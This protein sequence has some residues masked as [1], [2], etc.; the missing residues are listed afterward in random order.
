MVFAE[1]LGLADALGSLHRGTPIRLCGVWGPARGLVLSAIGKASG[2]PL[3]VVTRN[4][5]E[6]ELVAGD[7]GQYLAPGQAAVFPPFAGRCAGG[8]ATSL[9]V[10]SERITALSRLLHRDLPVVVIPVQ[11]L[12]DPLIPADALISATMHLY[13]QRIVG[14]ERV[15]A[16]LEA[17]GYQPVPQVEGPGTYSRRGGIVDIW[18]PQG[19]NPVRLEFFGD[20]IES[21]REFD[22]GTQRSLRA[23][24]QVTILPTSEVLLGEGERQTALARL[25]E[26]G[27]D[28]VDAPPPL[29]TAI[30]TGCH[31]PGLEAH[32]PLFY[33]AVPTLAGYLSP[34]TVVVWDDP[35]AVEISAA[36]IKWAPPSKDPLTV[37]PPLWEVD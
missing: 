1:R 12:F 34:E 31:A 26:R 8:L 3:L 9:D 14:M 22:G 6:A 32:L 36:E 15:V 37:V 7:L 21:L 35:G 24:P 18:P 5:A 28:P 11:A 23:I 25:Q 10:R 2:R 4:L 16:T 29:A 30:R 20:A 19:A 13:P 17:G 33:D 27:W